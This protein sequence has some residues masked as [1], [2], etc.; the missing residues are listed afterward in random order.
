MARC[1]WRSFR[2]NY[3]SSPR[4]RGTVR[5]AFLRN[6]SSFNGSSPRMRGTVVK[7]RCVDKRLIPDASGNSPILCRPRRFIPAH[8][9]NRS[10]AMSIF[11]S[12]KSVHPRACGEQHSAHPWAEELPPYSVHPRACGEQVW[13]IGLTRT[14]YETSVHP[15]ACGEQDLSFEGSMA[16]GHT[17]HPRACGEQLP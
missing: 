1:S 13:S 5:T 6:D 3:G 14:D 11:E 4:M 12:N 8:A 17:V 2:L 10:L 7:Y 9:G 16:I 15:R